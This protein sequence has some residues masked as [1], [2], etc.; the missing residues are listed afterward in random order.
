[1]YDLDRPDEV[2]NPKAFRERHEPP[3]RPRFATLQAVLVATDVQFGA[4]DLTDC[5]REPIHIPG[6]IQPH[7]A[8]LALDPVNLEVVQVAGDVQGLLGRSGGNHSGRAAIS[9]F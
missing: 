1:L 8:L 9:G 6:S 7:G 3:R 4:V 5:D 2:L